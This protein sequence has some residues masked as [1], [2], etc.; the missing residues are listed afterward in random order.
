MHPLAATAARADARRDWLAISYGESVPDGWSRCSEVDAE[1]IAAWEDRV[2]AWHRTEIGRSHPMS[3]T[4]YVL[5]Y[6]A[7]IAATV[8]GLFFHV[9]RRV[10][11][12][13]RESVA[14]RTEDTYT[15]PDGVVLLDGAFWCLPGDEAAGHPDATV[16]PDEAALAA[17]LRAQVRD[18][19]DDFLASYRPTARLPRRALLGAFFDA[20]DSG[21]GP[22]QPDPSEV[23]ATFGSAR[24]V[25]PGPTD[26]FPQGSSYY[27]LGGEHLI[28]TR[29][30]CCYYFKVGDDGACTTCPRT[31]EEERVRRMAATP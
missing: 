21:F 17:V 18:H 19:A 16:V 11:S 2:E 9:D 1:R 30:G 3:T 14:F 27:L 7:D 12:L 29:V 25:L 6:Y 15:Y 24:A 26:Q 13:A 28:R 5:S 22:E 31:S 4:G 8:G 23:T 10:P 20:L